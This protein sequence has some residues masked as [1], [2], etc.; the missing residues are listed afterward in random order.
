MLWSLSAVSRLNVH[1]VALVVFAKI[2]IPLL[3]KIYFFFN[4]V[5]LNACVSYFNVKH[6]YLIK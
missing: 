5:N 3:K 6:D 4:L 1:T 2:S